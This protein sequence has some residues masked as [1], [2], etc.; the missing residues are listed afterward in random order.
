[1]CGLVTVNDGVVNVDAPLWP[2]GGMTMEKPNDTIF[3]C[4][5]WEGVIVESITVECTSSQPG[6]GSVLLATEDGTADSSAGAACS[7]DPGTLPIAAGQSLTTF[8]IIPCSSQSVDWRE[9]VEFSMTS[10][11]DVATG[12]AM[13]SASG[14]ILDSEGNAQEGQP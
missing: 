2:R 3:S 10:P 6:S 4:Q 14:E 12:F 1:M 8:S 7:A 13:D 9:L 5:A 11:S